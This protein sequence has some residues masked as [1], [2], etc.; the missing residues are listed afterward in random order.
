MCGKLMKAE[1]SELGFEFHPKPLTHSRWHCTAGMTHKPHT[2]E[3]RPEDTEVN[4]AMFRQA[5][6]VKFSVKAGPVDF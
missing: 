3:K 5:F 6:M 1:L 2:S 4:K